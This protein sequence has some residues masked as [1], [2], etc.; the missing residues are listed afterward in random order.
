L[1]RLRRDQGRRQDVLDLLAPVYGR[2]AE[3]FVTADLRGAKQLLDDETVIK[4]KLS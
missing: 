1:A 3:G 2:F 4:A